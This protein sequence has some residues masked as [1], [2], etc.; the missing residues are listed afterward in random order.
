T[1]MYPWKDTPYTFAVGL[2]TLFLVYL[3]DDKIR[4]TIP[5]AIL[6]AVSLAY[7]T[8][9][10]LNGIVILLFVGVW[11]LVWLI[12]RKLWK[13]FIAMAAA[14]V[15][16]FAGVN[17]YGYQ[18]MKAES[19]ENGFS[20]Q[21]FGSGIAAMTV[22]GGPTS[23]Y[24][25]RDRMPIEDRQAIAAY[26]DPIWMLQHYQPWETRHIIW[27]YETGDPKFNDPNMEIMV[28]NFVLDLGEHKWD[29]VKLYLK[30]MPRYFGI[31]VR[32]ILYNT[33]AVWGFVTEWGPYS[34]WYSNMFLLVLLMV[35][36]GACWKKG[37]VKKR[38]IVFA[39]MICNA[40]SIAIS[41]ITNETRYLLP[42][43]TLF[44]VMILYLICTSDR[45]IP[46]KVPEEKEE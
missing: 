26:L 6:M 30:L 12:R 43:H 46:D 34:F 40:V 31:C 35:G 39:P 4:F 11:M 18:V 9:F 23:M 15:I 45:L 19:P 10:R 20:I 29:V 16:C 21:V 41:T 14:V 8:L 7:T 44:P 2:L 33:Y 24:D 17:W 3:I 27:D 13:Q 42:T 1:Y 38:M 32:D 25:D 5:K 28:N 22:Y 37:S 36:V